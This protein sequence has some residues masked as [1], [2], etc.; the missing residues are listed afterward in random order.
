MKDYNTR[1]RELISS[2]IA[3]GFMYA[4]VGTYDITPAELLDQANQ[5]LLDFVEECLPSGIN[6]KIAI[7]THS[8]AGAGYTIGYNSCIAEIRATAIK[9]IKGK[10]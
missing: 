10:E 8:D 2:A 1:I 5:L 9:K 6:M 4:K 7:K 3:S